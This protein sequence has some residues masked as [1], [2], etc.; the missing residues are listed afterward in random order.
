MTHVGTFGFHGFHSRMFVKG[1]GSGENGMIN[2][3]MFNFLLYILTAERY[4]DLTV[5][6]PWIEA[7]GG[8]FLL[9]LQLNMSSLHI[10]GMPRLLMVERLATSI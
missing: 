7:G 6:V 3:G 8:S 5:R 4:I 1:C 2:M 10:K 9:I